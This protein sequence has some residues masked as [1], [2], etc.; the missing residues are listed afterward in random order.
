MAKKRLPGMNPEDPICRYGAGVLTRHLLAMQAEVE[1]VRAAVD[2]EYVH[3]MRVASR[4]LR[5]ALPLFSA[6]LPQKRVKEWEKH[7]QRVTRAL[8]AARDTDVHLEVLKDYYLHLTD[9]AD[10]PGVRRLILRQRQLRVRLQRGVLIALD[11]LQT[12]GTIPDLLARVEPLASDEGDPTTSDA[13]YR[14]A[15]RA[16]MADLEDMLEYEPYL[17]QPE[18]VKELHAMR[19]S[20]KHLRYSMEIFAP[21]Y[22]D[23]LKG[24]LQIMRKLQ[25]A[26]GEIHDDDVWMVTLP[27]FMRKEARRVLKY[28]GSSAPM[29]RLTPGLGH[30]MEECQ[31]RRAAEYENLLRD[32]QKWKDADIWNGLRRMVTP[33]AAEES[34]PISTED[35]AL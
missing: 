30:F 7:I 22:P 5:T 1:G 20:A 23:E 8:G 33:P 21:I 31:R 4:R 10:K 14:L 18:R 24:T 6:C 28:T 27:E 12:S 2:V 32:W 25:T 35:A 34:L 16:V 13:L 26:L 9:P 19:I 17:F 11:E 3:R 15:Q 29:R